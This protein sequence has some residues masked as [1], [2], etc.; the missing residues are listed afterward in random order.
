MCGSERASEAAAAK[1]SGGVGAHVRIRDERK[2]APGVPTVA[3][4]VH[5]G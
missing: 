3:A 1:A 4:R 5:L 2:E